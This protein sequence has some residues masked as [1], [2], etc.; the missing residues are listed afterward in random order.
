MERK[1]V[2]RTTID[3]AAATETRE[4]RTRGAGSGTRRQT[5]VRPQFSVV[6]TCFGK[7]GKT[8]T[9][10]GE[11]QEAATDALQREL[12]ETLSGPPGS[13]TTGTSGAGE[14]QQKRPLSVLFLNRR[15]TVDPN[16]CGRPQR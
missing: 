14:E 3:Q 2:Q 9:L 5:A 10:L 11:G 15:V 4:A 16:T 13:D 6:Q 8:G 1:A 12:P 7:E